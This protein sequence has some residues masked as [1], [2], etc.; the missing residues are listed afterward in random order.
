MAEE[1]VVASVAAAVEILVVEEEAEVVSSK[2]HLN[3]LK[4]S[5]HILIQ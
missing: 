2:V 1:E 3:M 5:L 4:Q